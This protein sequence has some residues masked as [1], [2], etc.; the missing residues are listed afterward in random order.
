MHYIAIKE[1]KGG[2]QS[3]KVKLSKRIE[4]ANNGWGDLVTQIHRLINEFYILCVCKYHSTK[5]CG[6][7]DNL[8]QSI[9]STHNFKWLG[10]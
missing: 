5:V 4:K 2:E 10:F 3:G 1:K 8:Q 7:E 9:L 6:S